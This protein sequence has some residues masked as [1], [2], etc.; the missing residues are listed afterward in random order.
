MRL[1][2]LT[3]RLMF[4]CFL[5]VGCAFSE[6]ALQ[7][8]SGPTGFRADS[9]EP[10]VSLA[11]FRSPDM[12]GYL[13]HVHVSFTRSRLFF[14]RRQSESGTV[15]RASY[16]WRVII[17]ERNALQRGGGVYVEG[18]ELA[19][20]ELVSDPA[21]RVRLFRQFALPAGEYRVEVIVSDRQSIRNGNH[22]QEIT[23]IGYS[24]D[25]P[26][27]SQIEL[28]DPGSD[29]FESTV[30]EV[31][32]AH[33]AEVM[34]SRRNPEDAP[35]VAFLYET[36][37]IPEGISVVN[38]LISETGNEALSRRRFLP[39]GSMTVR[40]TLDIDG[41]EEG[42]Y[43]LQL[44]LEGV[45][46]RQVTESLMIR[47]HRPLLARGDDP[48]TAEAQL[49]L[50][51]DEEAARTFR[52]L[53]VGERTVFLDSLW[54]SLDPTPDTPRNEAQDEFIRRLR[55]ADERWRLGT[56]RGWDVDIGRV[57]IAFG[58]PDEIVEERQ[59][60]TPIRPLDEPRQVVLSKWIYRDSAVT[61]VF[62]HEPERG[63]VLDRERSNTIPPDRVVRSR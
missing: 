20:E 18:L 11:L 63:W 24:G 44:Q 43:S 60:R 51:A 53:P 17:R 45:A 27:L 49:T 19:E 16:E 47:I 14:L 58:E 15:W 38:R 2:N 34:V 7:G 55:Y 62:I 13:L 9:I 31:G 54:S 26:A 48:A 6:P 12:Q 21:R 61:F 28:L 41:L 32:T 1:T 23:A 22:Q 52:R 42:R 5:M 29:W 36:Y 39:A 30:T 33:A 59:T 35:V 37:N 46:G 57:Y 3:A 40:D 10:E 25:T 8:P 56:R 50:F 4:T